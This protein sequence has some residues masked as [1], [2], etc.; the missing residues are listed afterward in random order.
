MIFPRLGFLF[1][2]FQLSVVLS[3]QTSGL[4]VKTDH[5]KTRKFNVVIFPKEY[6]ELGTLTCFTPKRNHIDRAEMALME[7]L[8]NLNHEE[9]NQGKGVGPL[10]HKNLKKYKRQYFGFINE[11]GEHILSIN[12]FWS[13]KGDFDYWKE[14]RVIVF[15]G[16][17]YYW[18][19]LFNLESG[20][21]YGLRIN[22]SA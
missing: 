6:E 8:P 14:E 4:R 7:A 20:E 11:K 5:Y 15:D 12:C 9:A 19:V 22:G 1:L 10:I 16:G 17:S 13:R 18:T 3:A 21:L 2:F